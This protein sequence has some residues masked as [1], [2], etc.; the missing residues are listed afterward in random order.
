M[1]VEL[2]ILKRVILKESIDR[3]ATRACVFERLRLQGKD[4]TQQSSIDRALASVSRTEAALSALS[5]TGKVH[6]HGASLISCFE[7]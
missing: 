1:I 7:K 5:P 2:H 3:E 6:T 4:A